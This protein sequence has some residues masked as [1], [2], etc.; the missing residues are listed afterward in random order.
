MAVNK[1]PTNSIIRLE[2]RTG[3]SGSG[4]PVLRDKS[5][6]SVKS[7]ASDQD[8]Y[9]VATSL[10]NLQNYPLNGISRVDNAQLINV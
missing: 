4:N 2:L 9:D 3:T 1:V 5:L 8:I 10:A 7:T 6:N